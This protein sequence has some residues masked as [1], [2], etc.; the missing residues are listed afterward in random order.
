[1][2]QVSVCGVGGGGCLK[3]GVCT[4]CQFKGGLAI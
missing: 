4:V 2:T 3:G 1:M